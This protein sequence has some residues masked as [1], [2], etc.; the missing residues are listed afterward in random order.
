MKMFDRPLGIGGSDRGV[1]YNDARPIGPRRP[2]RLNTAES[3]RG[4][5]KNEIVA[6]HD[7]GVSG[8][9]SEERHQEHVAELDGVVE[10]WLRPLQLEHLVEVQLVVFPEAAWPRIVA[11][12]ETVIRRKISSDDRVAVLLAVDVWKTD[13]ISIVRH[14][15]TQV[16]N[17][18]GLGT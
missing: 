12:I 15:E 3:A 18:I 11:E 2:H 1:A 7:A 9:G 6:D 14:E 13:Q 10:H 4:V 8:E 17:R 16:D 5:V